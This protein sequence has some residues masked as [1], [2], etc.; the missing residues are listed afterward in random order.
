M[1]FKYLATAAL[2][3]A[4]AA[5]SIP[6]VVVSTP[7]IAADSCGFSNENGKLVFL[8]TCPNQA[9]DSS[10]KESPAPPSNPCTGRLTGG[11]VYSYR[12]ELAGC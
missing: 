6:A 5:G 10:D 8:G 9:G 4:F 7:A 2:V 1:K 11:P 12:I 3:A